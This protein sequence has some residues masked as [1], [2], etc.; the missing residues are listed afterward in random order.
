[1]NIFSIINSHIAF[2]AMAYT[3]LGVCVHMYV[4]MFFI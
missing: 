1:M 3:Y 4:K 2:S